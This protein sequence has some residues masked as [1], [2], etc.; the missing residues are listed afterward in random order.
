MAADGTSSDRRTPSRYS[1]RVSASY[2][3]L[4]LERERGGAWDD[5][6]DYQDKD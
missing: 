2:L 1:K 5:I 6:Y 3:T 4:Y